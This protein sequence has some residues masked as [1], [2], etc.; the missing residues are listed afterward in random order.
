MKNSTQQKYS[1]LPLDLTDINDYCYTLLQ[2]Q[3]PG[4]NLHVTFG[5]YDKWFMLK[6]ASQSIV[7]KRR[8]V[9]ENKA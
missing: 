3:K 2:G 5:M 9:I 8:N 4:E 6:T 7:G 1:S